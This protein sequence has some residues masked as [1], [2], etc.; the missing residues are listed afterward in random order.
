MAI[1]TKE[2]ARRIMEKALSFSTADAC[3]I[4]I[5][6]SESGNIR[7]ARNTVS[8]SGHRSNQTLVVQSNFGLKSGVATID[9]FDDASLKKVVERAEELAKLAP[10]NPEFMPPLGPQTYD[11]SITYS[12]ATA[13]ITPGYRAEV[14][15]SS[16]NPAASKDVTSAG[17]LN[18]SAGFSAMLNSNG[19]FAYNKSTNVNFTVTMRTN[20]GTGSGWVTRDFNDVSK[21]DAVEASNVAI[22]KAIMSREA[23]AIEPGKYTVILEPAASIG[24][25]QNMFGSIDARTADEGRSFMSKEGGGNKLGEKI[26]DE[27]INL[28][29]DPLHPDVPTPTWNGQ[30]QPLKKMKWIENGVVKNLAYSR[31]WAKQKGVDPVPFP[32]NAIMDGG[33]ASL[34]DLIKSTR[35]GILVTR[36]WYIRGVDPQTLLYTGL[37][38][39]GTFYI[40]N[41]RIKHPVKNFRFNE[42]PIIMLNN[43]EELG[44]QVRI[45]GNLIPYMKVRDFTFTSLSDAV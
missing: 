26:I 29:S 19:L 17:F 22:D 43:L 39:D 44:Q 35:K 14:A 4:N 28:W 32:S 37:T 41:G 38:R 45:N 25:L 36:L 5:S 21:F 42:S 6:G 13:N 20:D 11:E 9:E 34:E 10:E 30:G 8:T 15:A 1:Y 2:E 16:I 33:N 12:K 31:Y 27:R 23:K 7:Y 24:L 40:E 3:E 18:D